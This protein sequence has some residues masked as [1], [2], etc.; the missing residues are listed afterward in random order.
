MRANCLLTS[1]PLLLKYFSFL[2]I[3]R[4]TGREGFPTGIDA[5]VIIKNNTISC[6]RLLVEGNVR[7]R[8]QNRYTRSLEFLPHKGNLK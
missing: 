2:N 6:V 4:K 8:V 3:Q 5:F 1:S 7:V